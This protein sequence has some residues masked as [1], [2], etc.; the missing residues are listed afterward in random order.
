MRWSG[1]EARRPAG[2]F[3]VSCRLV[4]EARVAMTA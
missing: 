1:A 3:W 4:G 2:V